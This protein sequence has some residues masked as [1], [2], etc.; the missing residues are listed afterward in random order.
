VI[1]RT[2]NDG[3]TVQL[4]FPMEVKLRQWKENKDSVSVDRG[5]LTYSLQIQEKAVRHGGTDEWPAW[6]YRP[7]SSW[8]Y[9]L[10]PDSDFQVVERP[11]PADGQ[12][13]SHEG[14]PLVL[15]ATGRR[16]PEWTL[17]N[18][19]LVSIL[20]PSPALTTQP[21]ETLTLV[22]MGAARLRISAFP[23]VSTEPSAHKWQKPQQP[24]PAIPATAS[25]KHSDDRF[26][27]LSDGLMPKNSN[28]LLIPRFTW[29]DHK[30]TT[31][32]VQ[33]DLPKAINVSTVEVY[34]FDDRTT[35][36]GCRVPASWRLLYFAGG[37]W[38]EV[39]AQGSYGVERDRAN[40]VKF[41]PVSAEKWRLEAKL[42]S[43]FSA[44]ILE[45]KLK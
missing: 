24:K 22:P 10:E 26:E 45:W 27:A 41:K 1:D 17:D 32:W 23:I 28:D 36:G 5:P 13:F 11:W 2:W 42:Q 9:G 33:Y 20:Q 30:G 43:E 7:G 44:G 39:G 16:I 40:V 8:N 6:E 34:W 29:W 3:D 21:E 15:K 19:G 14:A 12:P 18:Y 35:G 31:E 25:H 37:A 4:R 38:H